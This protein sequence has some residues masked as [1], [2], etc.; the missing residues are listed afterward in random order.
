MAGSARFDQIGR[1]QMRTVTK[2]EEIVSAFQG[3]A[4]QRADFSL[5]P[6][7]I[8]AHQHGRLIS[9]GEDGNQLVFSVG[10]R[11]DPVSA[12]SRDSIYCFEST[13]SK[14]WIGF[15]A[16]PKFI[17]RGTDRAFWTVGIPR[18]VVCLQRRAHER[19][20]TPS[21]PM[22]TCHVPINGQGSGI[23]TLQARVI[24]IS[25]G[26]I[27]L[28]T[29]V[30]GF[31][32]VAAARYPGCRLMLTPREAIEMTVEVVAVYCVPDSSGKQMLRVNCK[33]VCPSGWAL[34]QLQ[35]YIVRFRGARS[36]DASLEGGSGALG[37]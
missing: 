5:T 17:G 31:P 20:S 23:S 16:A 3:L 27:A 32:L 13:H 33:W 7:G 8:G 22:L 28:L 12:G 26:G 30:H 9:L 14:G 19:T 10:R 35:R 15:T 6:M 36:L 37:S 4:L 29:H 2:H 1:D 11:G 24:D 18:S 25:W 34:A 21:L